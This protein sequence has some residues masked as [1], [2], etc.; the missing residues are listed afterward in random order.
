[1]RLA[2]AAEVIPMYL[3][4]AHSQAQS[5]TGSDHQSPGPGPYSGSLACKA[6][7]VPPETGPSQPLHHHPSILRTRGSLSLLQRGE[8]ISAMSKCVDFSLGMS[9]T[10]SGAELGDVYKD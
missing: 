10:S 1:M 3:H 8:S 4:G 6:L 2:S 9:A 7:M 5:S